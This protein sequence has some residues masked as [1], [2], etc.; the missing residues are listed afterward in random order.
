MTPSAE[1]ELTAVI[2][3][4]NGWDDVAKLV[5]SLAGSPEVVSG[6]CVVVVVDNASSCPAPP[7]LSPPPPGVRLV[8]RPTNDGFAAGVNAGWR[9]VRAPWVL[10]LNPDVVATPSLLGQV[11]DRARR[12][13]GDRPGV[14]GFGLRNADGTRQPSVGADPGLGRSLWEVVL[15]RDRRKYQAAWRTRTGPVPW[16]TGA[17]ALVDGR[18]LDHLGGMDEE[19]FLYYEE[20]AL[21]RSA[22]RDGWRV[23]YDPGIEV[24]HLHPLQ[25]RPISPKMRVVTRHSRLLYF[26]K[27]LPAWQFRAMAAATTLEAALRGTWAGWRG[28]D[29]ERRGWRAVGRLVGPMRRGT[30]PR[31]REIL[32][33][34]EAVLA[35][36]LPTRRHGLASQP[37]ASGRRG[38]LQ[39]KDGSE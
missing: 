14:L 3:N 35:P 18:L 34:A 37:Q 38:E 23:E 8:P 28:R 21:C 2:V 29:V 33:Y 15:P 11:L 22:R 24:V 10:L 30:G 1:P 17:C 6:R 26:R 39:R 4:Y 16:V 19:F 36:P 31:G 9:A 13:E 27:H 32:D 5:A 12:S 20:V 7:S 25:N